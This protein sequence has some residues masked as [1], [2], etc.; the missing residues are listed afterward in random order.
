MLS[1]IEQPGEIAAEAGLV[2]AAAALVG[3]IL[4]ATGI[5]GAGPETHDSSTSLATLLPRVARCRESFYAQLLNKMAGA[6]G[7]RLRR[8]AQTTKQPF[9]GVRQYLNQYM[10]RHRAMQ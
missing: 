10:A 7:E 4:M 9:G 5:S 8:E 1:R 3:T 6:H 2:E